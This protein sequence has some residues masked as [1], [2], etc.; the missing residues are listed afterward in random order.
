VRAFSRLNRIQRITFIL[1]VTVVVNWLVAS[2]IG[3]SLLGGDLFTI[4]LIVFM[5]LF[6]TT[7]IRPLMRTV[8]WRVRNRLFVTYFLIGALRAARLY[9]RGTSRSNS[10]PPPGCGAAGI[11]RHGCRNVP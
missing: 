5:L 2:T 7:L 8:L 6:A 11:Q 3:Y 10:H 9:E 4:L 1:F